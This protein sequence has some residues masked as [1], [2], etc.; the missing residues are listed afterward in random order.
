VIGILLS[1][2][3]MMP[4]RLAQHCAFWFVA[5]PA[6]D[7]TVAQDSS[8]S[9][10]ARTALATSLPAALRSARLRSEP[11]DVRVDAAQLAAAA[12]T[13]TFQARD[14]LLSSAILADAEN[15]AKR[16][17]RAFADFIVMRWIWRVVFG[18][19]IKK[20]PLDQ[21]FP[22]SFD[23]QAL[24]GLAEKLVDV[25]NGLQLE[26]KDEAAFT[27]AASKWKSLFQAQD[28]LIKQV[29]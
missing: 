9:E 15:D 13:T 22:N 4:S 28:A 17:D 18:K 7:R 20:L 29:K 1:W 25:T 21:A 11:N 16:I 23:G 26:L 2:V 5:Q 27:E 3:L 24:I 8:L 6:D 14:A 19:A 10:A 12:W